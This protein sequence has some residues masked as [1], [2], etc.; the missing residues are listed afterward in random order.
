MQRAQGK[1]G[2]RSSRYRVDL[3][4][5]STHDLDLPVCSPGATAV[6]KS[7]EHTTAPN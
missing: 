2:Y 6:M 1:D 7:F 4:G 3:H 5:G